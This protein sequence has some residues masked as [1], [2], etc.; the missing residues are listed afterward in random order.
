MAI[1]CKH[2]DCGYTVGWEDGKEDRTEHPEGEFY[3]AG[4]ANRFHGD[5]NDMYVMGCPKCH[6]TFLNKKRI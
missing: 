3:E 1:T 6:R 4:K 2:P 5:E